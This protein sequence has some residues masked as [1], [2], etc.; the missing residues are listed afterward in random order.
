M[1]ALNCVDESTDLGVCEFFG[2]V[3]IS[4]FLGSKCDLVE[5]ELG[6][7]MGERWGNWQ[8]GR[9]WLVTGGISNEFEVE[10]FTVGVGE[11]D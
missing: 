8:S 7:W 3:A 2:A 1:T 5:D 11:A 6:N 4:V 10:K 9:F